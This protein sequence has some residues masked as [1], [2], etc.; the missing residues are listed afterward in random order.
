MK[1]FMLVNCGLGKADEIIEYVKKISGVV[2]ANRVFGAYDVIVEF[3][4]DEHNLMRDVY[5]NIRK[6]EFIRST[7]TLNK[8]DYFGDGI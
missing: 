6:H 3:E 1:C 5:M 4:A 2:S 7:M 8:V